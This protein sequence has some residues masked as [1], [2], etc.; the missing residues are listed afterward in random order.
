MPLL[1][2]QLLTNVALESSLLCPIQ[3]KVELVDT[4][5]KSKFKNVFGLIMTQLTQPS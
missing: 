4:R 3:Y 1:Q 2:L 5:L